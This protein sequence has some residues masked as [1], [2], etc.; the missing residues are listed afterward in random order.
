MALTSWGLLACAGRGVPA[1]AP[2]P[3]TAL[4]AA[5]A[6]DGAPTAGHQHALNNGRRL[7]TATCGETDLVE[8]W[9]STP[10]GLGPI[11]DAES[12][13][14]AMLSGLIAVDSGAETLD[15]V[16]YE[17]DARTCGWWQRWQI[18]DGVLVYLASRSRECDAASGSAQTEQ[19]EPLVGHERWPEA[20]VSW[21]AERL[22][23]LTTLALEGY[24][25]EGNQA[26]SGCPDGALLSAPF[27]DPGLP[28]RVTWWRLRDG[29]RGEL[30]LP[31]GHNVDELALSEDGRVL[32]TSA[33]LT[34]LN[35][36]PS[37]YRLTAWDRATGAVLWER[38]TGS[39]LHTAALEPARDGWTLARF[40]DRPPLLID[41]AGEALT[42]A[43]P[44]QYAA[45]LGEDEFT[46]YAVLDRNPKQDRFASSNGTFDAVLVRALPGGEVL[47]ELTPG[48]RVAALAWD[49][50]GERLAAV[51]WPATTAEFPGPLRVRIYTPA[52][53]GAPRELDGFQL[54]AP[55]RA[56]VEPPRLRFSE[57][58]RWLAMSMG[59]SV[60]RWDLSADGA[61]EALTFG[62][63]DFNRILG[64]A[65][66]GAL[67]I[68]VH[69]RVAVWAPGD[70]SPRMA[71]KPGPDAP[72]CATK[73]G[74][75]LVN[76]T[77]GITQ[78]VR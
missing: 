12:G 8:L 30:P 16:S 41:A 42:V 1:E 38:A 5:G 70:P 26:F 39:L 76:R 46:D 17:D 58:G 47:T 6:C 27:H 45:N 71:A 74:F 51:T 34:A 44:E 61:S 2:S 13:A 64:F 54:P 37:D 35:A 15:T 49:R 63:L 19:A 57:D 50:A 18:R 75:W 11:A 28:S 24:T 78:W 52:A 25:D 22:R 66:D 67:M 20:G 31:E 40:H 56:P 69:D 53:E 72:A 14:P 62:E 59:W 9:L 3:L 73:D 36:G 32:L 65:P 23:P 33:D 77:G 43:S 55:P 48:G 10:D 21:S 60:L 4:A 7:L 68:D 29:E